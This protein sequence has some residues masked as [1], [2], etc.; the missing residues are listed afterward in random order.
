MVLFLSFVVTSLSIARYYSIK[1]PPPVPVE[2]IAPVPTVIPTP[3][4]SNLFKVKRVIDG[5]T[6]V[7]EDNSRVRL[8]GINAPESDYCFAIESTEKLI[9]L[10]EG[11]EVLLEKDISDVDRYDRLLRYVYLEDILINKYLVE[12]GYAVASAYPP[13]IK[14]KKDLILA[15]EIAEKNQSGLWGECLT[16]Q[17][18]Q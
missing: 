9:E 14:F 15:Q 11:K 1:N 10:L 16:E 18:D 12:K 3:T 13:D 7:L 5:D 8:I 17:E 2:I 6:F 4:P